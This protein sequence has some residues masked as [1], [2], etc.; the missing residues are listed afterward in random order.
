MATGKRIPTGRLQEVHADFD[1]AGGWLKMPMREILFNPRLTGQAKQVWGW[2]SAVSTDKSILIPTWQALE[3]KL[4]CGV[5]S[6]RNCLSQLVEEGFISI[7]ADGKVV[8][9]YDPVEVYEKQRKTM[10]DEICKECSELRGETE[11]VQF[12]VIETPK[13]QENKNT[14]TDAEQIIEAWNSCKPESYSKIRVLSAKQKECIYKHL[15]NLGLEKSSIKQFI[16]AV[17]KGLERSDFWINKVD[18]R[19]KNFSAVFGYGNPN[20]IKMKNIENLFL[21]GELEE[22]L[23]SEDKPRHYT[24][25]EQEQIDLLKAL[26][27]QIDMEDPTRTDMSRFYALRDEAREKLTALGINWENV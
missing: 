14:V 13:K 18:S 7:S 11:K 26:E 9:M 3:L 23:I 4:N 20:D 1:L 16:C 27:Y 19:T 24:S 5:K 6:R 21:D 8:T 25:A 17:C 10:A 15:N 12:K 22:A 2:L